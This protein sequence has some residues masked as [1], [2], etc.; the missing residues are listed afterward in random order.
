MSA[1]P[2]PTGWFAISGESLI[3]KALRASYRMLRA[4][5]SCCLKA[6]CDHNDGRP[7]LQLEYEVY[8]PLAV[9][10]GNTI[11]E[12]ARSRFAISRAAAVHRQGLLALTEPPCWWAFPPRTVAQ[13][14]TPA[15]TSS[16]KSKP[17]CPSGSA[18]ITPMASPNG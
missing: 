7:V 3:A 10:E 8:E 9:S 6:G 4:A 17:A 2:F 13:P 16:T 5:L 18:S 14:L 11:I 12:E 15:A 1:L